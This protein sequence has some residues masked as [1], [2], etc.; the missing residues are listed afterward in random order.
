MACSALLLV[1]AAFLFS[2]SPA[3]SPQQEAPHWTASP[4]PNLKMAVL[5]GNPDAN[6]PFI[7][8]LWAEKEV[9]IPPHSHARDE[10]LNVVHGTMLAGRGD[11]F[12]QTS[13][14]KLQPG[15]H[16]LVPKGVHHYALLEPGTEVEISGDGPFVNHWV[17]PAAMKDL[18]KGVD[19]ASDRSKLKADQ[20]KQ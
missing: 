6:G 9:R 13:M 14:H 10:N 2:Q 11:H 16:V 1:S 7:L 3:A 5:S 15:E 12:T 20:D 18:M 4:I 17:D 19:S 8:R